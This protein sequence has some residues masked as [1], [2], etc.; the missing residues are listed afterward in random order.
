MDR[1][2]TDRPNPAT[3]VRHNPATHKRPYRGPRRLSGLSSMASVS[4]SPERWSCRVCRA[5]RLTI[6]PPLLSSSVFLPWPL[7]VGAG[8]SVFGGSRPP[9]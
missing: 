8:A 3:H 5:E 1:A 9:R 2:V 7:G 6:L 4:T